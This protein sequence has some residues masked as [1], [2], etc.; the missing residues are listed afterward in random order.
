MKGG[1]SMKDF[2]ELNQYKAPVIE[3]IDTE[4]DVE[5]A[6]ACMCMFGGS[7]SGSSVAVSDLKN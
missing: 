6:C 4:E 3:E 5:M 2:Q 7:G 1:G